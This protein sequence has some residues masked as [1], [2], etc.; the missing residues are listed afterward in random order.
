MYVSIG[1]LCILI[2][3]LDRLGNR[4]VKGE[5]EDLSEFMNFTETKGGRVVRWGGIISIFILILAA[6]ATYIINDINL[7]KWYWVFFYIMTYGIRSL[8][9]WIY[10]DGKKHIFS[11]S[12]MM[13]GIISVL[14]IFHF[15]AN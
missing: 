6:T 7:G 11:F 13:F 12:L 10:L 2:F 8:A 1:M 3:Y 15:N 4:F 9:E 14:V 5:Y